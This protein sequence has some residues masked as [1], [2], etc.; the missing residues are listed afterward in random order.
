VKQI[1]HVK[2]ISA[3]G[4]KMKRVGRSNLHLQSVVGRVVG[5]GLSPSERPRDS[6]TAIA[7]DCDCETKYISGWGCI[8]M[9]MTLRHSR[10]Y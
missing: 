9:L 1:F 8:L 2:R 7:C 5:S 3:I 4:M 10:R 6:P